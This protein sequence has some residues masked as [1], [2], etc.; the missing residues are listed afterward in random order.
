VDAVEFLVREHLF[1][2]KTATRRDIHD[3]ETAIACARRIKDTERLKMLY[4]LTVADSMATGPAAWND[5]TS[6]LLREFFFKAFNIIEKGELASEEAV[7][8]IE[9]KR[10]ALMSASATPAERLEREKLYPALPP[11]YLLSVP[12]ASI[13]EHMR[14]FRRLGTAAF[15]WDVRPSLEGT[16]RTV[17]VCAKDRPGLVSSIAGVFTLNAINILGVQVFTWRNQTALDV[18]EVT[19]PPDALF[20]QEKWDRAAANLESVLA[21]SLDLATELGPRLAGHDPIKRH[22][23]KRPHRVRI[24]NASS[25]F[26]TIVEI[27]TYDFPGLLYSITDALFRC[28]LDIW[29]AKIATKVDQVVDVFYIRDINGQKVDAPDRVSA[30][31]AAVR[32]RLPQIDGFPVPGGP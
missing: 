25:S 32:A 21:G 12:A 26:F 7:A 16:T 29:V 18:F 15:M 24:D 4:I 27:F 20:E 28:G 3:E 17:T 22:A 23:V 1:L 10:E 5:W 14:L 9:E 13:S 19:P 30:I 6:H 31:E 2:I 11:R 8:A